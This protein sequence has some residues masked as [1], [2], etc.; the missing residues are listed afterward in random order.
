M[1][2]PIHFDYITQ[3]VVSFIVYYNFIFHGTIINVYKYYI[4]IKYIFSNVILSIFKNRLT[5]II[6]TIK[7]CHCVYMWQLTTYFFL[8]VLS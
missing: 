5:V 3:H 8:T 4:V 7:K 2:S 6:I 1:C